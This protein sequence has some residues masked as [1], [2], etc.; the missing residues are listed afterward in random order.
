M[1]IAEM[2]G[3]SA[4]LTLIG[5]GTVFAF[6]IVLIACMDL[7][8]KIVKA[9]KWD[10]DVSGGGISVTPDH[11]QGTADAD[12]ATAIAMAVHEHRARNP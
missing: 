6:L 3:Q 1:T 9:M 7:T 12:V 11:V 8:A 10:K 2:F 4:I 5:M